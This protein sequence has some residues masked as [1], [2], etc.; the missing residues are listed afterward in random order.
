MDSFILNALLIFLRTR[1]VPMTFFLALRTHQALNG[2]HKSFWF[3]GVGDMVW[4]DV[5]KLDST[6]DGTHQIRENR[7]CYII[8]TTWLVIC[9]QK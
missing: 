1:F 5:S 9:C 4:Y 6:L 8:Y 2:G 7:F 3:P